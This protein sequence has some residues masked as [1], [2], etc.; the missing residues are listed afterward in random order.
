MTCSPCSDVHIVNAKSA[1]K[2]LKALMKTGLCPHTD[3]LDM[4]PAVT[5]ASLLIELVSCTVKIA[6]SVNELASLA[7][8]KKPDS[9]MNRQT[10]PEQLKRTPSRIEVSHLNIVVE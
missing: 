1:A 9:R 6:D 7:N 2:K 4:I 5:V 10:S 8:F 3:V